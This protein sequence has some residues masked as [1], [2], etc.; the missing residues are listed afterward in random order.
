MEEHERERE[1]ERGGGWCYLLSN[2]GAYVFD[3]KVAILVYTLYQYNS[4]NC[5]ALTRGIAAW[6][7]FE[8]HLYSSFGLSD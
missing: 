5:I 1:R 4:H 3:N 6:K 7:G 2:F 8:S